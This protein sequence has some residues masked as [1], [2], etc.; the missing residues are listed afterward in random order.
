[1]TRNHFSKEG[2]PYFVNNG[3]SKHPTQS[4]PVKSKGIP[5][6]GK[7]TSLLKFPRFHKDK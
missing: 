1:M 7:V 2:G 4:K 3:F 6:I 5:I